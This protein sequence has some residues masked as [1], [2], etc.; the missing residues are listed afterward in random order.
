[1][2]RLSLCAIVSMAIL[3]GCAS[4]PKPSYVSPTKYQSLNCVQLQS[5]YQRIAQHIENG[6]P[7]KAKTGVGVGVGLGGGWGSGG[8]WGIAPRVSVN[9]GQWQNSKNSELSALMGE[10]EAIVQAARF[11]NC[12]MIVKA[13]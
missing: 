2:K 8:G 12:P 1:M 10:Q 11:K 9:L 6:V 7:S 5:E 13:K 3:T 4:T